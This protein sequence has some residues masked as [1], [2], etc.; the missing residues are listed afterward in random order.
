MKTTTMLH[1]VAA[2][3]LAE[4]DEL[5]LEFEL[6]AAVLETVAARVTLVDLDQVV[7][8]GEI[9]FEPGQLQA[10]LD[11]PAGGALPQVQ[12]GIE[13]LAGSFMAP[14][15]QPVS[16]RGGGIEPAS[17]PVANPLISVNDVIAGEGDGLV[18]FV[19]SLSAPGIAAVSVNFAT[20]SFTAGSVNDF[21]A[22]NGTLIFAPGET[23]KTVSVTLVDNGTQEPLESFRLNLSGAAGGSI[24]KASGSAMI[25]DNDD[26][27]ATPE[28]YVRDI[29]VD[30]KQ[31][32]ATFMVTLGETVGQR[33]NSVVTVN[34]ATED[35]SATAGSDYVATN[36][37]LTFAAGESVKLVTVDL[38]DDDVAEGAER[39]FLNLSNPNGAVVHQG[40]AIATIGANDGPNAANPLISVA[41]RTIADEGDGFVDVVVSLSAPSASLVSVNYATANF[42]AT[43][44]SDYYGVSGTLHF[45]PGETTKT[46]RVE[47]INNATA[48]A[49]ETFRLNLSNASGGTIS[50][51]SGE[52]LIVDNDTLQAT[53]RIY[54]R[55][56]V[57]DEKQGT[58][59]F[60]VTLGESVGQYSNSTVTVD[61][62]TADG[63]AVAGSDYV[64]TSGTLTF[65][66]GESAK[67]VTVDLIDDA[68]AEGAERFFL[69]LSNANAAILAVPQAQATI[70]A[71]DGALSVN[72]LISVA[73]Q[74]IVD[75]G[76]GF[77]DVVVSL[78]APSASTVSV[79]YATANFT[80]SAS[81]DYYGVS[82]TLRFLP[83][84][85][86]K[87]VRVEI[88]N[89]TSVE[90]LETF[91]L[92]LSG[93]QGG[94]ISDG[95]GQVLIFD[96]DTL[97]VTP[98][99][100]VRDI[101]VDEKQGT[102]T[103]MVTLGETVGQ[104]STSTVTVDYATSNGSAVA[105]SDYVAASGTLTFQP[106]ESAKL[107]TV[108]LIDDAVA[109]GAERFFLNL[110]NASGGA[111]AVPRAQ[112]TIGA[113]DGPPVASPLISV[114]PLTV[115]DEGDGFAD[116]VVSL[117]APSTSTVSVNYATANFTASGG[118]DYAGYSG[119]LRFL[120]GETTKVVRV[121]IYNNAGVEALEIFRLNLSNASGGTI[122]QGTG[123]VLIVD[124]DTLQAT[125]QIY[126]RDVF[127]DEKDG[128]ANF[129]V[130]LGQNQGQYATSTLTVDF[131]TANGS[132]LAGSDYVARSGTLTF[133][134]GESVKVV[135]VD[136]ID[137]GTAEGEE[138]FFL[139]LS[140]PTTGIIADGSAVARIGASDGSTAATPLITIGDRQAMERQGYMEFM[141]SLSAPSTS[142]VSVNFATQNV[143]ASSGS[144]Y[145]GYSG[146]LNFRPG[147]T[148]KTIRVQLYDNST[149]EPTE[150]F[151]VNLSGAVNGT[152]GTAFATGTIVDDDTAGVLVLGLGDSDDTY[153][154]DSA[155]TVI[156]ENAGGGNDTVVASLDY[157]LGAHL[158]NLTLVGAAVNGTGNALD[159]LLVGNALDNVLIGLAGNDTLD[160]AGGADTMIGGTGDDLYFVNNPGDLVVENANE[161]IDTVRANISYTL[162]DHVENLILTGGAN[163]S[164]TG[165]ALA[166]QITGNAGN[167]VIDGRGGADTM[168][169]GAGDDTYIVDDAGDVVIENAGE[170]TDS[171][172]ASVSYTLPDHVE[173]LTLTGSADL[174][175]TGNGA[176]NI[177]TGNSGANVIS[178]LGGND[179]LYGLGGDD[180]LDGGAGD[181]T[182]YGG[183][184]NDTL[185]GGGGADLMIGGPGND[186]YSVESAGDV[187]V[188]LPGGGYDTVTSSIDYTLPDEVEALVL[189]GAALA[190]TG[191]VLNNNITGNALANTLIGLGG[192]DKLFGGAGDDTLIGGGGDD[193]LDG[194]AGADR[195]VGGP[196][197]DTYIV[198][199]VGDVIVEAIGGG[200]DTVRASVNYTLAPGVEVERF[201][202][203]GGATEAT[204][205]EFGQVIVGTA[206]ND[207]L[208]G[209]GGN[210]DLRGG[211][212][213]DTLYGG[214]GNDTLNGGGGA[215]TMYGGTGDD[216][217]IVN[218]AGDAV[219]ELAGQGIDT[220][221]SSI[222]YVL[223]QHVERLVL[224]G[225]ALVG[226]GNEL[227]NVIIGTNA[228]NTLTGGAGNDT[229]TGGG[230]A[231]RFV[232]DSLVGSDTITDF[233][234]GV[235][236]I[237]VS[238][239][240]I[241]IRDGNLTVDNA[242]TI[243]GPGGFA[244]NAEYVVVT[245]NISGAIT[246]AKAA[247][248]IGS[249]TGN[250]SVGAA[251]LFMV[252]N[253]VDSALYLFTAANSNA[254][255]EA[256]ELTLLAT[257]AGTAAT[258]TA[259]L[260]FGA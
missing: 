183:G 80:A 229:L 112:A 203:I 231:D 108:D 1:L 137:D 39:F 178:G 190:G 119:T 18:T 162:V 17:T 125:P 195:M 75:E 202:L 122:S 8:A 129:I 239:G 218:N 56:I 78:S 41:Q 42:T 116:I 43:A 33:S 124:N 58:A 96:N 44:N 113:N 53:P 88:I 165:N 77:V 254:A 13:P 187:V 176:A 143:T 130:S 27:R 135:A 52:V 182:L 151:R 240:A 198:D 144:D 25:V 235:D 100:H 172:Q 186:S 109:E 69:N 160:G 230:G 51:G 4:T 197:S 46:V 115:V 99:I 237:V 66:P 103:F 7:A 163:I 74:T 102:A 118:S 22:T 9:S 84:E 209:E 20:A 29:V 214:S 166:N 104:Y 82:G 36:G 2:S 5:R 189:I 40:R 233:T 54:V 111:I 93:A 60:M 70:G 38:I 94:T 167:N 90:S 117:S 28:I 107:V 64:A 194:G 126:V 57:V 174:T 26:L 37:T 59:T 188:E 61:Y 252:D 14:N 50:D 159:N 97:Q 6:S 168:A 179:I 120:P 136:I 114:A 23:S 131:A 133:L 45:L 226:T 193:T 47:L 150:T 63:S 201:E 206:G 243:A 83:G 21:V 147:E 141:V 158:E 85:T 34:Y 79:N 260:V 259:D 110:S 134:P 138:R 258:T 139:N 175:G 170:G 152:L 228:A 246:A 241:P 207:I 35:G 128:T 153:T 177:I 15:W 32:T 213:N 222:D 3:R 173:N 247:A 236:K 199:N 76:D 30:E 251:R 86:T 180:F 248:A 142:N 255:V 68:V 155:T 101:V 210:D 257:L 225:S 81:S 31:G 87:T 140:N 256:A 171:V 169:G 127:V 212:G 220:V 146:T 49:L 221:Q 238:Q 106:G 12:V 204:G 73:Q 67:L 161:G 211:A 98:Q 250:Y 208:R 223:P 200:F 191:N 123:D 148:T 154:V 164:G 249:A 219:I 72:P 65:H 192:A 121:E 16:P 132:A 181:D 71:S 253:G 105:G 205:N 19:V 145:A 234:S 62:A 10:R 232:L 55:D 11:L 48:E 245:A 149:V 157:V 217:Y 91:R 216:L 92:N 184:G 185:R 196:G 89:N 242:T 24:L 95:S 215:D 227:D 244:V 224:T 156:V